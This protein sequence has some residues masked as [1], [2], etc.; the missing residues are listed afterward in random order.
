MMIPFMMIILAITGQDI[1]CSQELSSIIRIQEHSK[2]P[3]VIPKIEVIKKMGLIEKIIGE[4]EFEFELNNDNYRLCDANSI[5]L[6]KST[7]EEIIILF[8]FND[9]SYEWKVY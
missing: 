5:E 8:S 2:S 4:Q 7:Q 1:G 6:K 3:L 9:D